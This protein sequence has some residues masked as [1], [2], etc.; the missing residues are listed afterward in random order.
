MLPHLFRIHIAYHNEGEIVRDVTRFVI[1][2]HLLLS[3]LVVNLE[4]ADDWKPVGMPLI[5]RRK[6][7][8]T[9]HP[10]GIVHSHREL[11]PDDFLLF[12]VFVRRQ[13]G[14]H[15]RIAQNLERRADA[16]FRHVNPEDRA[17]EGGIGIY[18]TANVLNTLGNLIGRSRFRPFEQHVLE[19]VGQSRAEVL[20]LIDASSGAP[21]LHTG[22]RRAVIFLHDDR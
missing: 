19:N 14:I 15:H 13:G 2:H 10:I 16:I 4:F 17:I 20:V 7:K 1:L 9:D 21:R 8:E 22:Y 18:I 11:A 3:E 12:F 5:R 6:K